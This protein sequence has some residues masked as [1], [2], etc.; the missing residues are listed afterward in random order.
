MR[1]LAVTRSEPDPR[2]SWQCHN[3]DAIPSLGLSIH[4][5][6]F[7]DSPAES[8]L[9]DLRLECVD[10]AWPNDDIS[11]VSKLDSVGD[12]TAGLCIISLSGSIHDETGNDWGLCAIS[13]SGSVDD[14]TGGLSIVPASGSV[15]DETGGLS[16][17][18]ALG[19]VDD[20][21]GGLSIVPALGSVDD[22]TGDLSIVPALGSVDDETG[23]LSI[24]PASGSVHDETGNDWG[25]CAITESGS[26]NDE[27]GGLSIVPALGSVDDETGGLFIVPALGSVDDETGGLSIV[28][29][30]GSVHDETGNDW[31]LC[32]I[33]K[34]D[35]VDDPLV[36][37]GGSSTDIWSEPKSVGMVGVSVCAPSSLLSG[38]KYAGFTEPVSS[39]CTP[40][41]KWGGSSGFDAGTCMASVSTRPGSDGA[42]LDEACAAA[43]NF[44]CFMTG[45]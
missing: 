5:C 38:W 22:E 33:S 10:D 19:F 1:L 36:G 8:V 12:E 45:M 42:E 13:E 17:V 20:E 37:D 15:D 11:A 24:V 43:N 9:I 27:T 28:P 26:V 21:T 25:L 16:I 34:L 39:A 29:A 41:N 23:G 6:Q 30:S 32:A 35:S 3:Y 18:P 2:H 14:G 40:V 31:G 4:R 44:F 7:E